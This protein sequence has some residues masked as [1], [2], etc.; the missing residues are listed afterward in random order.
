MALCAE[1]RPALH[2]ADGRTCRVGAAS[3]I[4]LG[5]PRSARGGASRVPLRCPAVAVWMRRRAARRLGGARERLDGPDH[6]PGCNNGASAAFFVGARRPIATWPCPLVE[7]VHEVLA[8]LPVGG[9][10]CF[11]ALVRD[12]IVFRPRPSP[13]R[14][15]HFRLNPSSARVARRRLPTRR[16]PPKSPRVRRSIA[17]S[18]SRGR[19]VVLCRG[20]TDREVQPPEQRLGPLGRVWARL[21]AFGPVWA[22]PGA[23]GGAP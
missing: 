22:R 3:C 12:P 7:W 16:L 4:G 9:R 5:E 6:V 19:R 21:G 8:R 13:V 23:F 10:T 17:V 18:A 2:V 11:A 1:F 14:G 20:C 15:R